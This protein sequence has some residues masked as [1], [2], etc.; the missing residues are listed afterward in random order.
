MAHILSV[1]IFI[2]TIPVL[3]S[4]FSMNANTRSPSPRGE[5]YGIPG[6]GWKSPTWNWGYGNG[7]GHDCAMI[8][9]QRWSSPES[10][11]LLLDALM[12][13]RDVE[14][15]TIK[16]AG[17]EKADE[18]R[19][20]QFEE[21]KLILGLA[22]QKYARFGIDGG[23][24]GYNQVLDYMAR[25]KYESDDEDQNARLFVNDMKERFHLIADGDQAVVQEM[26]QLESACAGDVDLLRRKCT[27]LV[28]SQMDFI[29]NGL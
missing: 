4:A 13:P 23:R 8:C 3:A 10:R 21:V 2:S 18:M 27:A 20:P 1:L 6:S 22:L 12:N 28:L 5:L 25:T 15:E 14:V 24:G 29:Q 11:K 7:T 26:E 16:D 17:A 9:R 19:E